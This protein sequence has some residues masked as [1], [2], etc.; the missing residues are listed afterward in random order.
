[1][2]KEIEDQF[3]AALANAA[4]TITDADASNPAVLLRT[5]DRDPKR[6]A[7]THRQEIER[8]TKLAAPRKTSLMNLD[9]PDAYE[10]TLYHLL[11]NEEVIK[12]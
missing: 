2:I 8:I 10:W 5:V 4:Y 12:E 1:M 11:Q 7:E 6:L 9:A 3:P